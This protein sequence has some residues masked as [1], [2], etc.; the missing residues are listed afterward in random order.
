VA[1]RE[2][3]EDM[4][5]SVQRAVMT[6]QS[7]IAAP[8]LAVARLVPRMTET[9]QRTF[10]DPKAL[11][12]LAILVGTTIPFVVVM[13]QRVLPGF[14]SISVKE[15]VF[16]L[17]AIHVPL[18]VYLFFDPRI[19]AYML[20]R[21]IALIGGPIMIFGVCFLVFLSTWQSREAGE[22]WLVVYFML[23]MLAWNNWHFGKQNVGVYSFFRMSQSHSGTIPFERKMIVFGAVLG[24][25]GIFAMN[26][27]GYLN[28][29]I[30]MYAKN[31]SFTVTRF[32][33]EWVSTIA[34][35]GQYALVA[36]VVGYLALNWRRYTWK[37]ATMFFMCANFF[38][39]IYVAMDIPDLT[40]V[41]ACSVLAHGVQYCVFLGFHAG[42]YREDTNDR[43]V[44]PPR[45]RAAS[46]V[47][48]V[49]LVVL[50]AFIG[51]NFLY[52]KVIPKDF[53]ST[54]VVESAGRTDLLTPVIDAF[55][56]GI[57]L[58]HFW[59]DSFFWRF[60]SPESRKWMAKRYAFLINPGDG[61]RT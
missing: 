41:F 22:A 23:G 46:I 50:A 59:L 1:V 24:A 36:C 17:G 21:P 38:F 6:R 26:G 11:F 18:T 37:T 43:G 39:P 47:M 5:P 61:K 31:E 54:F 3:T 56:I 7:L 57:L 55:M 25:V 58:S 44:P 10:R 13:L 33:A 51:D 35:I 34:H 14:I 16:F 49:V 30:K 19:R 15:V 9:V 40:A 28:N 48:C 60:K 4:G 2:D 20:Q 52:N 53:F 12:A 29:F 42:Q 27:G 8:S 45:G 32:V